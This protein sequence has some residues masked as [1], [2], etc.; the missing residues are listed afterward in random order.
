MCTNVIFYFSCSILP[1][2]NYVRATYKETNL[3]PKNRGSKP[4]QI[5]INPCSYYWFGSTKLFCS[6]LWA[7]YHDPVRPTV[8]IYLIQL[9]AYKTSYIPN[10]YHLRWIHLNSSETQKFELGPN[11]TAKKYM[12][13]ANILF[14]IW[15]KRIQ[16][17][18]ILFN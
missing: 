18:T 10:T 7:H 3:Y 14:S 11:R 15:F 12:R 9:Q 4:N 16:K 13:H 17:G 2:F 1:S 5:C 6:I 8:W